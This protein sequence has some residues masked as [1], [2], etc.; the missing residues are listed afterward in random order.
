MYSNASSYRVIERER[1]MLILIAMQL[2]PYVMYLVQKFYVRRAFEY[3][4]IK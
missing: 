3:L 2:N 1:E 4:N